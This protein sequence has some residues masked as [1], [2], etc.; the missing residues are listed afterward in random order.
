MSTPAPSNRTT[1]TQIPLTFQNNAL[2]QIASQV[3]SPPQSARIQRIAK[4]LQKWKTVITNK[5]MI[6]DQTRN[7]QSQY[8]LLSLHKTISSTLLKQKSLNSI[9]ST[10]TAASNDA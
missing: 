1:F 2:H 9:V 4:K 8:S 7:A 10:S 5:I 6:R 3:S